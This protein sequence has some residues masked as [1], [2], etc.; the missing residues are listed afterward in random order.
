M[1]RSEVIGYLV[2]GVILVV[3]GAF[4]RTIVLNWITGPAIVVG[5]VALSTRVFGRLDAIEESEN[6]SEVV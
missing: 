3:G 2:A 4:L 5:S 6:K 1:A